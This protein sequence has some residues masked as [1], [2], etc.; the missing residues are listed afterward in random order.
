ML[1]LY[2]EKGSSSVDAHPA[3]VNE[4]LAQG[5]T[6]EKMEPRKK[7]VKT[8]TSKFDANQNNKKVE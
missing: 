3:K 8:N 4:M 5:W 2:N 7:N 1:F 6:T